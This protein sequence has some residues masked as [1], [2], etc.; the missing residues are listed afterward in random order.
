M[1]RHFTH[2]R[3]F[4]IAIV[5]IATFAIGIVAC[6]G[7]EITQADLLQG[8]R[9]THHVMDLIR[10]HGVNQ[11]SD[12]VNLNHAHPFHHS[13][14]GS[15]VIPA[16]EMG[17]LEIVSVHQMVNTDPTTGPS[18]AIVIANQSNR[19]V[20]DFSVTAVATLGRIHPHSPSQTVKASKIQPGEALQVELTLP[21]ES[22]AMGNR[23][24]QSLGFQRL[25]IAIDSFDVLAETNEANNL[26]AYTVAS[27]P[28]VEPVTEVVIPSITPDES[29]AADSTV[30]SLQAVIQQWGS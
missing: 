27:I 24:G 2:E 7:Q 3:I 22:L 10:R 17:D 18:F 19:C 16:S 9:S 5:M 20:D 6:H 4:N 29:V 28:L 8:P 14:F 25:I 12:R 13:A 11:S 21:I 30:D 26:K 23:N 15:M 1:N